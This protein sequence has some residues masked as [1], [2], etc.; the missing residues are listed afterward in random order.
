MAVTIDSR[1]Q[2]SET[3]FD[4]NYSSDLGGTPTFFIYQD[5]EFVTN[6]T[7]TVW[8]F[9]TQPNVSLIVD[10]LDSATL[11][12][13]T[14]S[15]RVT[16]AWDGDTDAKHYRIEE[17]VLSTW[18]LRQ[19]VAEINEGSYS[20]K[21]RWLEDETTHQFRVISVGENDEEANARVFAILIVR[22][23]D[24]VLPTFKYDE[25]DGTVLVEAA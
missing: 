25:S 15:G 3:V 22:N 10:I 17:L 18:T 2:I 8:T 24:P 5:G 20:W 23:P 4:I 13:A 16:I 9:T 11:P 14:L 1:V 19:I 12:L 7:E 6:T 21:S